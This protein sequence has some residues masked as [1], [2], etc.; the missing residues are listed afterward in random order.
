[1]PK[2]KSEES[3]S[4]LI[5]ELNRMPVIHNCQ[6]CKVETE[7]LVMDDITGLL[8]CAKCAEIFKQKAIA[9]D[10]RSHIFKMNIPKK[11][12]NSS[13]LN[14]DPESDKEKA[15]LLALVK[16]YCTQT[17]NLLGRCLT[18][19]GKTGTGK[20]HLGVG[21]LKKFA[22]V[23]IYGM[24]VEAW[25]IADEIKRT[26]GKDSKQH[27]GQIIEKYAQMPLLFIDEIGKFPEDKIAQKNVW[28]VIS[29]RYNNNVPTVLCSNDNEESL[30]S[31]L[32]VEIVDRLKHNNGIFIELTHESYRR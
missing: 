8:L 26:W 19:F 2:N 25:K 24:Y 5:D 1:M 14:Y 9:Q 18:L 22:G 6:N 15:E 31:Y 16:M 28:K 30:T 7:D 20:T 29:S 4:D 12:V 10:I 32:S 17:T 23:K 3:F 13:L 27:E 21:V 11:F